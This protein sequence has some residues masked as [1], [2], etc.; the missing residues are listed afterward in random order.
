MEL[1]QPPSPGRPIRTPSVLQR[2]LSHFVIMIV[3]D[4]SALIL[5]AKAEV[6]DL[7]LADSKLAVAIPAEVEKECCGSKKTLDA[8]MIQKA[9]DESR[10]GV[11]AAKKGEACDEI[12]DRLQPGQG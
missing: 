8:L 11:V 1:R 10:I 4:A 5:I 9:L 2:R 12:G 3:F 6:L 7:F